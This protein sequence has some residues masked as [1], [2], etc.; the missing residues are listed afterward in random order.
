MV[1]SGE[2]I[3]GILNP[4]SELM[5]A[6][7]GDKQNNSDNNILA[8]LNEGRFGDGTGPQPM[9]EHHGYV[10]GNRTHTYV[11]CKFGRDAA[12][13]MF[14]ARTRSGVTPTSN[15]TIIPLSYIAQ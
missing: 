14:L 15:S 12:T 7:D 9:A 5:L 4:N 11:V 8:Y 3:I 10:I 13:C 2:S 6:N 1:T